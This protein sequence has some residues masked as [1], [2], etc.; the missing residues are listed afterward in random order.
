M[1]VTIAWN[2]AALSVGGLSR[3]ARSAPAKCGWCAIRPSSTA[4]RSGG[5]TKSTACVD[6]VLP[7]ERI[8]VELGRIA[9][10][11]LFAGAERAER[12][13]PPTERAAQFHAIVTVMHEAT[14]IDFSLYREKT[15][16]RRI[17]RRLALRNIT[18]LEEYAAQLKADAGERSA[19]QRDLLICVTNFFRDPESFEALK[20]LVFPA[21][22]QDRPASLAIRI[23]A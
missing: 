9:H 22:L 6:F 14:G 10:H 23:W 18:R 17:L 12:E 19:L 7:P 11:P 5:R 2:W 21:I 8:A 1:T 20:K 15:V 3:S 4:I 16:Q 13:S